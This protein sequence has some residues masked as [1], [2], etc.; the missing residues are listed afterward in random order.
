MIQKLKD[1]KTWIDESGREIPVE[2]ISAGTRLKERNSAILAKEAKLLNKKLVDFKNRVEKLSNDVLAKSMEE[3]KANPRSQGGFI[4]FNFDRSLKIEVSIQDRIVFDDLAVKAAKDKL[5][6]FLG[7]NVDSKIEFVKDLVI[8]AFSTTKG[9][10]DTKKIMSLMK[11]NTKIKDPLFQDA[12]KILSDGMRNP[13]SKTYFR[14]FE[15]N[16]SGEYTLIDLNF[17]SL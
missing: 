9:N 5:D 11:Y 17:S 7:Q 13:S 10:I 15:R 2:Y 1:N 8:S 4:W 16:P 6:T 12:V 14:I 3:F